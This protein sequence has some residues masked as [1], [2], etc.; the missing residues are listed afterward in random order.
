VHETIAVRVLA[1]VLVL[2]VTGIV[3]TA[4]LG[5]RR[6]DADKA[7]LTNVRAAAGAAEAWYQDPFAGKG[8]YKGLS[9]AG[10]AHEAPVVSPHVHVTVLAGGGAYCLDDEEASGHS[11]YYVGGRVARIANLRAA[12]THQATLV[13]STFSDASA[14]CANAS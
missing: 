12:A 7:A 11:A 1:L 3:A 2:T 14:V 4:Y 8:S 13:H 10:L 9:A 5:G 6:T